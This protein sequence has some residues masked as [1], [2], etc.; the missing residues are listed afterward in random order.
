MTLSEY[1][2]HDALG[3]AELVARKQ[4]SARELAQMA[5]SAIDAINPAVNAVVETYADRIEDLDERRSAPV[6]SAACR[7]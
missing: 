5:A 7:S 3:L 4:V 6:R 2:S 1:S